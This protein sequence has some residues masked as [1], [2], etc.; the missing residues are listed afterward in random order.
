MHCYVDIYCICSMFFLQHWL[1][2]AAIRTL[3]SNRSYSKLGYI[4]LPDEILETINT[5]TVVA[6]DHL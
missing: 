1:S 4:I 3:T 5:H 2:E 6:S